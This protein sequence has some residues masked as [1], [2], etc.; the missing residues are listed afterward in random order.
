[1]S[2][3][4]LPRVEVAREPGGRTI[5]VHSRRDVPVVFC[6]LQCP[7]GRMA[8][9]AGLPGLA[10]LAVALLDEGPAGVDPHEWRR[11]LEGLAAELGFSMRVDH[12]AAGFECL[13]EDL[14][15]VSELFASA[16]ARP[17]L[18]RSEWKRIAKARRAG[19]REDWAQ[20]ASVLR[21]LS[22]VQALGYGHPAARPAFERAYARAGY[23][24]AAALA[25]GALGSGGGVYALV[26]GDVS[27]EDGLALARRMLAAL[28]EREVPLP[29]EPPARPSAAPVWLMDHPRVDQA[30][31]ALSRPGVRAG[32]PERVALRLANFMIGGGGFSS[33]LMDRIREAM[34]HTYGISSTLPERR[35]ASAFTVGS[36]TQ[37]GNL[38]AMLEL[39]DR[40]LAEVRDG[41]FTAAEL[42]LARSNN[43][44]RLPLR[45]VGP[46]TILDFAANGLRSGLDPGQLEADWRSIPSMSLEAVNAAARRLIGD[47]RWRLAVIAPE[48]LVRGQLAGR[49]EI[50][51]IPFGATPDRWPG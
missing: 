20:P 22:P 33:R 45:L 35:Q 38:G 3:S 26:G 44:G 49:G 46:R 6:E 1:M 43:Y 9:P 42:D 13:S 10:E 23:E 5:L 4:G 36:F 28:P 25:A 51:V 19:A 7:G 21:K 18:H 27:V 47:G 50:S 37:A 34:G 29:P 11:R 40:V 14:A 41:G 16:V 31:F 17:G 15:G 39:I 24:R 2:G 48:K 30:F 8:E 32:D 12:W